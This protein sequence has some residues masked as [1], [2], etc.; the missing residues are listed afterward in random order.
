MQHRYRFPSL[1]SHTKEQIKFT[2]RD[3]WLDDSAPFFEI[4]ARAK[5]S[6]SNE[7]SPKLF[8]ERAIIDVN[9]TSVMVEQGHGGASASLVSHH[10]NDR[11]LQ[12]ELSR[13]VSNW[14]S[15]V[16][17]LME[18]ALEGA[19]ACFLQEMRDRITALEGHLEAEREDP[20]E[21]VRDRRLLTEASAKAAAIMLRMNC[22][23]AMFLIRHRCVDKEVGESL[24][25][26][27]REA[28]G[29]LRRHHDKDDGDDE[30]MNL[31]AQ[32]S[33]IL[34]KYLAPQEEEVIA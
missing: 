15:E 2:I 1:S 6:F 27:A 18:A 24:L 26:D 7:D 8:V 5:S 3:N 19:P 4:E 34:E 22:S 14:V 12:D 31:S 13:H 21:G 32:A 29:C 33:S 16:A 23:C 10:R 28:F 11:E 25:N 9:K 20:Q 17:D 30:I